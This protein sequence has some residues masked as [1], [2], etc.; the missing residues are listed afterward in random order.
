[1]PKLVHV[2]VAVIKDSQGRV[3]VARR[4]QEA[5][6]GGKL[7]FPGGKVEAGEIVQEA[8]QRELFEELGIQAGAMQPLIK[9]NHHYT[10]KSVCLDVWQVW[11]FSGQAY[12][13]EGQP[14]FWLPLDQLN[15]VD[16][17]DANKAIITALQLPNRLMISPDLSDAEAMNEISHRL[18]CHQVSAAILR[19]PQLASGTYEAIAKQLIERHPQVR[20]QIHGNIDLAMRLG[21]GLHLTSKALLETKM[22][23]LSTAGS[24][25]A[26]VHN[27]DELRQ[28]ESIGVDFV[29]LGPVQDTPT[30]PGVDTLGWEAFEKIVSEAHIPVYAL[31]GMQEKDLPLAV[32]AGAQGVAGISLFARP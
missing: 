16:F 21:A 22:A 26:S 12:G 27:L 31:G 15:P 23:Q 10:D 11:D 7:E 17:P 13:K 3:L 24:L 4:A 6:M 25:S 18:E 5:H 19:L 20:W 30:H 2:A 8:L 28:A 14:I 9:I 29:V 32:A 1:M